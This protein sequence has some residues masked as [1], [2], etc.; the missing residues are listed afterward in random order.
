M[1]WSPADGDLDGYVL[2]CSSDLQTVYSEET[3]EMNATCEG[4]QPGTEHTI[5]VATVKSGWTPV[6]SSMTTASTSKMVLPF[7]Y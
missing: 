3:T 1:A 2:K 6:E 5:T 7:C 4:L